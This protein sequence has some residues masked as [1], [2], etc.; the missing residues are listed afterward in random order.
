MRGLVPVLITPPPLLCGRYFDWVCRGRNAENLLRG[1]GDVE[2]IYRWE[3][4]YARAVTKAAERNVCA[5]IDL[6]QP[7][8]DA[9]DFPG[10]ICADGIHPTEAGQ[11]LMA[12]TVLAGRWD[13]L[14]RR[15][16]GE[17]A[18]AAG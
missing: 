16:T 17:A 6:R 8:L 9:K 14:Y 12:K 11:E 10:L 3:E 5:C 1:I 7:F 2:H 15:Q 4:R 18:R 13:E